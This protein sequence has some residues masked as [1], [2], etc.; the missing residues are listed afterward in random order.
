MPLSCLLGACRCRFL[1]LILCLIGV[2]GGLEAPQAALYLAET[3]K[4]RAVVRLL[5]KGTI[6]GDVENGTAGR[7]CTSWWMALQRG[8][9]YRHTNM[10]TR[11]NSSSWWMA[12]QRSLYT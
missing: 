11:Q 8:I 3:L 6:E 9:Q 1:L 12:L 2:L 10:R 7:D 4:V 5:C